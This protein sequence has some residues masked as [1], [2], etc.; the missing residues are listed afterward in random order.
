MS[1]PDKEDTTENNDQRVDYDPTKIDKDLLKKAPK[2]FYRFLT[3]ILS[4]KDEVNIKETI[5]VVKANIVFRGANVWVLICSIVVACIGLNNDSTAVIIGAMLISPLMGPIRGIGLAIGTNDFKTL[6]T[7]LINFGV[8]VGISFLV[9]YLYFL[10]SPIKTATPELQ[11]RVHPHALDVLIGFFG[12]LAGIIASATG[13]RSTVVPGVAIATALMPPMCTA[14]YGL[15]VGQPAFFFGALYLF[16]LNSV[17]I[18]LSTVLTVRYL[19]FPLMEFVNSRTERKVKLYSFVILLGIVVPSIWFFVKLVKENQFEEAVNNFI[20]KEI[21]YDEFFDNV[22]L[23]GFVYDTDSSVIYLKV[24][25]GYVEELQIDLWET[26]LDQYKKLEHTRIEVKNNKKPSFENSDFVSKEMFNAQKKTRQELE[27]NTMRLR[28]ELQQYENAEISSLKLEKLLKV[29]YSEFID[30]IECGPMYLNNLAGS[31]D[32]TSRYIIYWKPQV[33][34]STISMKK[35]YL[36]EHIKLNMDT[37]NSK[38]LHVNSYE[39]E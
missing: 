9:A 25:S 16:L 30:S 23:S 39:Q 7:S 8:M 13:D 38:F 6:I 11:S 15:A 14:G 26:K 5:E 18:C 2:A 22:E 35:K 1:N 21:R 4:I 17:F 32:T 24:L 28:S 10:I 3:D 29:N 12:G 31:I 27:A 20:A 19:S 37:K 33:G 36:E 34:D